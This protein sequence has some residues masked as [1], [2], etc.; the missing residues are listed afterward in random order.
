MDVE[1]FDMSKPF[2][3]DLRFNEIFTY[4]AGKLKLRANT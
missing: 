3:M 1:W 2:D 4:I